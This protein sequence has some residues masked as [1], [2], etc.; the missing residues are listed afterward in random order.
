MAL[1]YQLHQKANLKQQ[2][3]SSSTSSKFDSRILQK[4]FWIWDKQQHIA[5]AE[6]TEG[7]CCWNHCVGLPLK[8]GK[9]Y[10]MFDYEK[11]LYDSL[12]SVDGSFKDKHL[13]VKKATGLG[14]TEFMLRL[15]AWLCTN[16][17]RTRDA[18][19][20]PC[21]MDASQMCIVTGP[22]IDIA[23]KL[24]KRMKNIFERRLGWTFNDKETVL[25]LNGCR[26]EAYPSNHLD[27]YRALT[28]PK[29]IF[30]DEADMFRK[31]E[32]DD[33]RH[34]TERYIGK[35]DP[36]IVMVSTPNAPGGLFE[37]IELES[38]E[39]C[40]YKRVKL[41]YTY[42]LDKIYTK[43]EIEKAKQSPSFGR[44]YDLKY[45]GKIGNIFNPSQIDR[46]IQ[47]GEQHKAILSNDY[48][49]HSVGVD[50][51]FGS[52]RT[53]VVLTEFLK[54]ERKIR[55]LYAEE[56]EHANPQDIVNLCFDLYRKHWNTWFW[57][58]GANR[59]FVN[60]MKVAFDES[61]TWETD[62]QGPNPEAW[63]VLPVNFATEHKQMLAHLHM[64]VNKQY[65]AIP[66]QHEKLIISL[67]TAWAKEYSLD[68]EQTSYSD[69]LDALRLACKM[70]KMN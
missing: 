62:K 48:T 32:Q 55:V 4:P 37:R 36:Y 24:I 28:N 50:T 1:P 65:L 47:L 2:Q 45:L 17:S 69:S 63:K 38:E 3:Q 14:V 58:D 61:L 8:D 13:W 57:I 34:V 7:Q 30:L 35:S 39:T 43:E 64:I 9:E 59:A 60:L 70:Y 18:L 29:F 54:E 16:V 5:A 19:S 27:S 22:N 25:H 23:I 15:M 10:P 31:S 42:G 26:I 46:V 20:D 44:E 12:M 52:S 66:Q 56:F 6:L 11:L 21:I 67:R 49:L 51:G 40:I 53:A 68:K 41:D 33:V